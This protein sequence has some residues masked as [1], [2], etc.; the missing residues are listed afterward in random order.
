MLKQRSLVILMLAVIFSVGYSFD[1]QGQNKRRVP[2]SKRAA[3]L[4]RKSKSSSA[5]SSSA[6][7]KT[8]SG[9][10][11]LITHRGEGRLPRAGE[12]VIVNYTGTLSNGVKFDSSRDRNQPIAFK[13]GAGQV[14]KGWDEGIARMHV[15]DQAI[16]VIPPQLGYGSKGV[17]DGLIPPDSTLI[18]IVELVDIKSTSLGDMLSQT[19]EKDGIEAMLARYNELKSRTGQ[20][21]YASESDMN[22]LGYRLLMKKRFPEAIAVFKLNVEAYPRSA[23]V[24]DSLGE[25]YAAHGDTQLAIETYR[26]ALE[27]DPQMESSKNA[28]QKL[29]GK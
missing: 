5:G 24:Y 28:L 10:T 11:Y 25:A 3:K 17:G 20:D 14:I 16:L 1:A 2:R 26:K 7:I 27:L 6:G 15:G 12:Y 19:L 9:L 8:G 13:L 22:A 21:I 29:T 18:F 4:T 23:N